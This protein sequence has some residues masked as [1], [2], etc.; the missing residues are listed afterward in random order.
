LVSYVRERRPAEI[1]T[2]PARGTIAG[3]STFDYWIYSIGLA[4]VT[5]LVLVA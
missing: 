5:A 4:F 2:S 1:E 3:M